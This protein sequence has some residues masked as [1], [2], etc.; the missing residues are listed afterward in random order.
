MAVISFANTKGGAGKTTAA[1]LLA[2]D[3]ARQGKRVAILDGDPQKWI[4]SWSEVSGA[5]ANVTVISHVT[6]SSLQTHIREMKDAVDVFII[7]LAGQRDTLLAT[8]LGLSDHVLIPVQGCAMDARGAA[9]VLEILQQMKARDGIT[10]AHSVVLTR[11]NSIVTTRAMQVIKSL[12]AS[13][14]VNVLDTAIVERTAYRDLFELGG[15]LQM[16]DEKGSGNIAKARENAAAFA[17]EVMRL[18]PVRAASSFTRRTWLP[19]RAA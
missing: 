7:D 18:V 4:T 13:R 5:V 11:V 14:G 2:M 1:L 15:T 17:A 8:A 6:P 9:Q 3:C 19:S 10:I 12:L 16:M